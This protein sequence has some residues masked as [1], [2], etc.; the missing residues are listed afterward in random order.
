MLHLWFT[1]VGKKKLMKKIKN[2]ITHIVPG[3]ESLGWLFRSVT[4][5]DSDA[6]TVW[7]PTVPCSFRV[8]NIEGKINLLIHGMVYSDGI[9]EF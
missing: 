6:V 9:L 5:Q 7:Y 2:S 3:L 1:S 8:D 4:R